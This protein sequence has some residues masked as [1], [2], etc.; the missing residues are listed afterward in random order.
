MA[1]SNDTTTPRKSPAFQFYPNDF[2]GDGKQA[3]MSLQECGLYIRLLCRCWNDGAIPDDA[4]RLARMTG[5]TPNEIKRIWPAVR[6]CFQDRGDG[7]FVH[8]RLDKERQK[9]TDYRR[10]QSDKG[11]AS[12]ANRASTEPQPSLNQASP[13]VDS[14][15]QPKANSSVFG[16]QSSDFSQKQDRAC[17]PFDSFE[18]EL[19]SGH[20]DARAHDFIERYKSLHLRLRSG[21]H[22]LGNP[23]R[24]FAE[25]RQ[26]VAVYDDARLDKLAFVWLNTDLDFAQNG[27]RT[28]AKFRSQASWCEEQLI[29]WEKQ[30]G[31]LTF[32]AAS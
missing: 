11:K 16:L 29:A 31:P 20:P 4:E 5:A 17:E 8:G 28:I 24:D 13:P 10:R 19:P 25:A 14:R 18:P 6:T 22:Y 2:L 32:E 7:W 15:L 23:V 3:A 26:L 12:A 30:H 9:Q 27:T 1:D 21:A